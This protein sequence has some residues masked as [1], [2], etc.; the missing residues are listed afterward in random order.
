[1]LTDLQIQKL[2]KFFSMY[3][4]NCDGLLVAHDFEQIVKKL[5]DLIHQGCKD[6]HKGISELRDLK[7]IRNGK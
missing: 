5:A 1:M 4:T 7:N 2:T 3:D 6:I